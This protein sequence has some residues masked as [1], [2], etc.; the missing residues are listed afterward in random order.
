MRRHWP[1]GRREAALIAQGKRLRAQFQMELAQHWE[2]REKKEQKG[3]V[4]PAGRESQ[5][6]WIREGRELR[7]AREEAGEAVS[8]YLQEKGLAA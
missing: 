7:Q 1:G 6:S 3:R 2:E 5:Q 4:A 8:G